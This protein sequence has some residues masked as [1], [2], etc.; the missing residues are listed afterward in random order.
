MLVFCPPIFTVPSPEPLLLDNVEPSKVKFA[1]PFKFVP[2]PPVMT[3]LSALPDI[4]A[5]PAAPCA[6]V[7]P[8]APCEPVGPVGPVVPVATLATL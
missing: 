6:P 8:V 4:V 7:D 3:R 2:L 5:E 1:S